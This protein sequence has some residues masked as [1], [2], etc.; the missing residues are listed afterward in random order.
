MKLTSEYSNLV[1]YLQKEVNRCHQSDA[2]YIDK[3]AYRCYLKKIF[4][5]HLTLYSI[6]R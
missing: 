5:K 6:E 4:R 3:L 1:Y 2:F